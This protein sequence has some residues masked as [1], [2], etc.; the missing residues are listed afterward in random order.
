MATQGHWR[1]LQ[2]P[3]HVGEGRFGE[4]TRGKTWVDRKETSETKKA[5]ESKA[6]PSPRLVT[7]QNRHAVYAIPGGRIAFIVHLSVAKKFESLTGSEDWHKTEENKTLRKFMM[8]GEKSGKFS[9]VETESPI[10][11]YKSAGA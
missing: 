8:D 9:I 7:V 6:V 3:T 4:K 2:K 1:R 11:P 10:I 5:K